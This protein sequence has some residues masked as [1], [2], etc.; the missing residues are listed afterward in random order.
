MRLKN[1]ALRLSTTLLIIAG[2]GHLA[3]Q[4]SKLSLAYAADRQNPYVYGHSSPN[5]KALAEK[6]RGLS[7]VHPDGNKMLIKV[8]APGSDYWPLPWYLRAF[9]NVGWWN[10]VPADPFAPVMVVS[11]KFKARFDEQ[12]THQMPAIF[13]L[14][15]QVFMELYVQSDLWRAY[16]EKNPPAEE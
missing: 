11:S 3:W 8:M 7:A 15:P 9:P 12:D 14:R 10:Q 16:L 1:K 5:V 2:L 13:S 4:A 6:I